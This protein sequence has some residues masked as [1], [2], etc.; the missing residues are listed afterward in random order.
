MGKQNILILHTLVAW[1]VGRIDLLAERVLVFTGVAGV[2]IRLIR[3]LDNEGEPR[4][5]TERVL[6]GLIKGGG[7]ESLY[8]VFYRVVFRVV[9]EESLLWG[10]TGFSVRGSFLKRETKCNEAMASSTLSY[11]ID[12]DKEKGGTVSPMATMNDSMTR[13]PAD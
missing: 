6:A 13:T 12:R 5:I 7:L 8:E 1:P 11:I 3:G 4:S 2:E 10:G 9:H